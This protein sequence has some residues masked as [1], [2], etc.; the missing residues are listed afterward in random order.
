VKKNTTKAI[1]DKTDGLK[2]AGKDV[3]KVVKDPVKSAA[4]AVVTKG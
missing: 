4:T 3:K 1:D 2:E